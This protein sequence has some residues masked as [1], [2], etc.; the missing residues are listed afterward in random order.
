MFEVTGEDISNLNDVELR[1]LVVKLCE[2]ELRRVDLPVSA[3]TAGG[4]QNAPDG[5]LDV[6][7]ALNEHDKQTDFI[8]RPNTGFQVKEPDMPRSAILEE[9]A[10][11]GDLRPVIQEL[12]RKQGAYVIVSSH[13]STAD[14]PLQ[15]RILAMQEAVRSVPDLPSIHLDFYDRNR[16]ATWVKQ[17]PGVSLWVLTQLGKSTSGWQGYGNWSGRSEQIGTEYLLDEKCRLYDAQDPKGGQLTV[18]GGLNRLRKLLAQTGSVVRLIG[19]SGV[20]KTRFVEALFDSRVGENAL[21][22]AHV[23]YTDM[24]DEPSPSPRDMIHRF[25]Q[26]ALRVIVVVDNCPPS[27]HQ[28]LAKMNSS[29]GSSVSILTVEYDV[30]ED[31]PEGTEVFRLEGASEGVIEDLIKR[32][33]PYISQVNRRSISEFSGGNARIALALAKSIDRSES[34]AKLSDEDLFQ[35]LFRQR[36]S[37]D[38]TLLRAAEACSLVYSFDGEVVEGQEAELPILAKLAE[39][40]VYELFRNV[41]ELKERE[42]VQ[43]RS[44]WRAVL[45]HALANKLAQRALGRTMPTMISDILVSEGPG[46]LLKSFSR[47]IGYLHHSENAQHIVGQW[48]SEGGLLGQVDKL[49]PLGLD[50]LH[51]I[52]PV[53][54]EATLAALERAFDTHESPAFMAPQN[55]ERYKLF[56]LIAALTFEAKLFERASSLL[57][58]FVIAEAPN[59]NTNSARGMFNGLFQLHLSGTHAS[60]QQRL[61]CIDTLLCATDNRSRDVGFEALEQMLET[62][63]FSS[64]RNFE[65]GARLRDYGWEPKSNEERADWYRKVLNFIRD[66][67]IAGSGLFNQLAALIAT[68]FRGLWTNA[69]MCEELEI[70]ARIIAERG[71]WPD[72]WRNV[73]AVI[74]FDAARMA[75]HK[76]EQIKKIEELLGPTS[77]LDMA[78]TYV[79]A[80][81]WSTFDMAEGNESGEEDD[82]LAGS[83]IIDAKAEE[84]GRKIAVEPAILVRFLPLAMQGADAGRRWNFG[85]GL[86]T[87]SDLEAMWQTLKT[88]FA[89]VPEMDQNE[90]VLKGFLFEASRRSLEIVT[91][92]LNSAVTDAALGRIFPSLQSS[93]KMDEQGVQRLFDSLRTGLAP[94]WMFKYFC[95]GQDADAIPP[96]AFQHLLLELANLPGG[97][98]VAIDI[99]Y[100]KISQ[101]KGHD[102]VPKEFICCG[103]ELL[104][105]YDFNK[106]G[107]ND[108]IR[109]SKI[110]NVCLN[111]ADGS[112]LA[113][114]ICSKLLKALS[115]YSISFY[116]GS[117]IA[118]VLFKSAPNIALTTFIL[119]DDKK[120]FGQ[121]LRFLLGNK[122]HPLDYIN[123]KLLIEWANEDPQIRF[124]A[125]SRAT[126]IFVEGEDNKDTVLSPIALALINAAP[127]KNVVLLEMRQ[128][129]SNVIS[130]W[131]P[132]SAVYEKR[133]SALEPLKRHTNK[134]VARRAL[135]WDRRLAQLAEQDRAFK[136]DED[137]RFE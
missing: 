103:R 63:H 40:S 17:Y 58:G 100:N 24:A 97:L 88:A 124:V 7:I 3:L 13:G 5:G 68:N 67:I 95:H 6:R 25:V 15:N 131:G 137:E 56:S 82:P 91:R 109:I 125:L 21:D 69:K 22:T 35:R 10:P 49:N 54:P 98:I 78:K 136:R 105:K 14:G 128:N 36:R 89:S 47:R 26:S 119:S 27:T 8:P 44:K 30:G 94:A 108:T 135:D 102:I 43:Q 71:G 90:S 84:I 33:A 86:A 18:E 65:F 9:M 75:P 99:L 122:G 28:A 12:A 101:L 81:Q 110:L 93:V 66:K 70:I 74:K 106:L 38:S 57:A 83:R 121:S 62:V 50:M 60:V 118:I 19:L 39:L 107:I 23:I 113:Q 116:E 53:N 4:D 29:S 92:L 133:R 45:P 64:H 123:T 76:L 31:E 16:L 55:P 111:N 11:N 20:G 115:D 85:V 130:V 96:T 72:G 41:Q 120:H 34:V 48:L 73:R 114:K 77:L 46:R 2:A 79:L 52:A 127:D 61:Q 1:T 87:V 42:L 117:E 134:T 59:N 80:P 112:S 126:P 32:V 132:L 51:N 37:E 104:L 129:L